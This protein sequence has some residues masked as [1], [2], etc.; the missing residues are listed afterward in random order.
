MSFSLVDRADVVAFAT[1]WARADAALHRRPVPA[2]ASDEVVEELRQL[3]HH[4]DRAWALLAHDE[5][6]PVGAVRVTDARSAQGAGPPIEG[7]AHLASLA[8]EPTRWGTGIG[9]ALVLQAEASAA[10]RG[11]SRIQLVVHDTNTR[12]KSLYGRLGWAQAND[13]LEVDGARLLRFD[14]RLA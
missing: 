13:H 6:V 8:V 12:A 9:S 1:V 11:Y 4:D 3:L 10:A 5:A 14:K 2:T 7:L